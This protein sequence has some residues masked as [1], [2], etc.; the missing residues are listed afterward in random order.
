MVHRIAM[1][2]AHQ[3]LHY[4]NLGI[5]TDARPMLVLK[6]GLIYV[7]L[8]DIFISLPMVSCRL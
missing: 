6:G 7:H 5:P 4:M 1:D 8:I 3:M 2:G